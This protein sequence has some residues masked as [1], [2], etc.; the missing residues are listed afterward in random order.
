MPACTDNM[1]NRREIIFWF[2]GSIVSF[3][4]S[5]GLFNDFS[6]ISWIIATI[7][8]FSS[9]R[10]SRLL[11]PLTVVMLFNVL[12]YV[13]A[14]PYVFFDVDLV[15]LPKQIATPYLTQVLWIISLFVAVLM[16]W[17]ATVKKSPEREISFVALA[18]KLHIP[19]LP[20]V[21]YIFI[22]L[23]FFATI[24]GISGNIV[25][26]KEG[27]YDEY[28]QN[29][30]NASG[31]QE[32]L[33]VV[34]FVAALFVQSRF[35]R[36]VWY[37]V[38][39]FFVVKLTLVGLRIVALMGV[40]A[41][42]W[43]SDFKF[44]LKRIFLVFVVGFVLFSFIGLL[45]EG[46]PTGDDA[47]LSLLFES[48]DGM[49]VSHHSNVLW[50]S[51]TMLQ[52]IDANV[53][54][55]SKRCEV[56]VYYFFNTLIPSG[57]LQQAF[58]QGYL[59]SWLQEQGYT[60]GG[61]HAAVYA[62]VVGASPGVTFI[63]SLIGLALKIATSESTGLVTQLSRCWL[64]MILITFPRWVSYDIGNFLFRLP[65][66][67]AIIYLFIYLLRYSASSIKNKSNAPSSS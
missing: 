16:L 66:Y 31:I 27:G 6:R 14:I 13:Y 63:A 51:T 64:M 40:L 52:L 19:G 4:G 5:T 60:S 1:L 36:F 57:M 43:F 18:R 34:F 53:I 54:D 25:L 20:L 59:G 41:G 33:L 7:I 47:L 8:G 24:F 15:T 17:V 2:V 58:G 61:G 65:I 50:A 9:I 42:L 48:Q 28:V 44:S 55:L 21:F 45:K 35:Q 56:F 67:A 30:Q 29:L 32:Y 10:T 11:P 37:F 3:I 12:F 23:I 39:A 26:G 38:L 46:L 49:V 22:A 62:Y